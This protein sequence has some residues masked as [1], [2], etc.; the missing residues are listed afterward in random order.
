MA[1]VP[2]D[3]NWSFLEQ[4]FILRIESQLD[5]GCELALFLIMDLHS[6]FCMCTTQMYSKASANNKKNHLME[7]NAFKM[8]NIILKSLFEQR[9]CF[10]YYFF[11]NQSS[12]QQQSMQQQSGPFGVP[13]QQQS[14]QHAG[15]FIL[16]LHGIAHIP[17]G[18][19]CTELFLFFYFSILRILNTN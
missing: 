11:I 17:S 3:G 15:S 7:E 5:I 2:I 19:N 12:G 14:L 1:K 18:I 9:Y 10:Y 8:G 6:S 16:L 4:E 13:V